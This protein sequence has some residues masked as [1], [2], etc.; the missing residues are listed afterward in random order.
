VLY[1]MGFKPEKT[2]GLE[3]F[4]RAFAQRLLPLGWRVVFCFE[5]GPSP[6]VQ[7]A[8]NLPNV[9]WRVI[10]PQIG[11]SPKRAV[12]CAILILR[13][14]PT[15]LIYAFNGV[16]R[17]YPWVAWLLGVRRIFYNDHSSRSVFPKRCNTLKTVAGR[18]LT[19]PL[20]A[21]LCVS[22][23]VR[24]CELAEGFVAP[25][26]I[27]VIP[28]GVDLRRVEAAKGAGKRFRERYGIPPD[29][30]VVLQVSWMVPVKGVD[31]LLQAA[32]IV[33]G[34]AP[35]AH[36]VLV[37]EGSHR[38]AYT[39]LSEQLG[40]AQKVTWTGMVA[41]PISEGAFDA[42]DICCLFSQWQEA[43][44]LVVVEAMSFG[45]PMV[46]SNAGGLPDLVTDGHTG[47]VVDKDDITTL[48]ER[49]LKLLGDSEC[50]ARLG[51]NAITCAVAR[52]D[53]ANTVATYVERLVSA[54]SSVAV[55]RMPAGTDL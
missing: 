54:P 42:A 19:L 4:C 46:A 45:V 27:D 12:E 7:E 55:R 44:P 35:E 47:Y 10:A 1:I 43:C 2:G 25:K 50:R 21:S 48:A 33:L 22:E 17:P 39:A 5:G 13:Y 34:A 16:L 20:T 14:R 53:L 15:A 37:G 6:A 38:P 9:E 52:F 51:Q 32:R 8:L 40:I 28:N 18:F 41:N 31:K 3:L 23:Y 36:F 11:L 24:R 29:K 49:I 26:R 30:K